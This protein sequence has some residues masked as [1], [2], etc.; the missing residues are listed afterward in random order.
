MKKKQKEDEILY[1]PEQLKE[2]F[3]QRDLKDIKKI[4]K[5]LSES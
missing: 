3:R 1:T 2:I 5:L 4:R